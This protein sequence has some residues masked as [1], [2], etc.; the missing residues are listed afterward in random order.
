MTVSRFIEYEAMEDSRL[1]PSSVWRPVV[2]FPP[3]S[4]P[5]VL[6]P[7]SPEGQS[8]CSL[9]Q[10]YFSHSPLPL[11]SSFVTSSLE[12][13]AR[14]SV[15]AK[16]KQPAPAAQSSLSRAITILALRHSYQKRFRYMHS[17]TRI[18]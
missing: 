8:F 13:D 2:E 9:D 1:S 6:S 3:F 15:L 4:I 10:N 5:S 12:L 17:Q 14:G 7:S 11:Y 18:V 16:E